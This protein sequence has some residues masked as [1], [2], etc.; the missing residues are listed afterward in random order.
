MIMSDVLTTALLRLRSALGSLR[1]RE[2]GQTMVEYGLLIGG[3][4]LV[5]IAGILILGPAINDLFDEAAS[6]VT[7]FPGS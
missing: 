3:I 6:S 1:D 4:A 7:N 5:V 2:E